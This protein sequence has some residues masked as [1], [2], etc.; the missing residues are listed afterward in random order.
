[1]VAIGIPSFFFSGVGDGKCDAR[2][3]GGNDT[4]IMSKRVAVPD[5]PVIMVT[6]RNQAGP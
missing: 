4:P 5:L 3:K 1:V 2:H 6:G